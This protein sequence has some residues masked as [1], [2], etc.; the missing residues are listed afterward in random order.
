MAWRV[1]VVGNGGYD[2]TLGLDPVPDAVHNAERFLEMVRSSGLCAEPQLLRDATRQSLHEALEWFVQPEGKE[3]QRCLLYYC[4]FNP[5]GKFLVAPVDAGKWE[6]C[7]ELPDTLLQKAEVVDKPLVV[8][9]FFACG[10]DMY[11]QGFKVNTVPEAAGPSRSFHDS[12][13]VTSSEELA[14]AQLNGRPA[15]HEAD[16]DRAGVMH[17][18]CTS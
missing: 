4:G 10:Q 17:V 1:L 14:M 13:E 8:C 5:F 7:L 18:R 12:L 9:A 3:S 6:D 11:A 16:D 15:G 2:P